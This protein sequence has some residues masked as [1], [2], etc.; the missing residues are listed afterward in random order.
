[1][2]KLLK[3]SGFALPVMVTDKLKSYQAAKKEFLPTMEHRYS[4]R[5]E[6]SRRKLTPTDTVEREENV[7]IQI[8]RPSASDS[9]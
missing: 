8:C 2:K 6:Q 4:Q 5:T 7:K 3:E 9:G 1:M